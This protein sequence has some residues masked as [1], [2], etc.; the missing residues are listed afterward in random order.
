[1][2]FFGLNGGPLGTRGGCGRPCACIFGGRDAPN[3][4]APLEKAVPDPARYCLAVTGHTDRGGYGWNQSA[5]RWGL[6]T[7]AV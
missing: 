2:R 3:V 1:M 4:L 7:R 5:E 6:W